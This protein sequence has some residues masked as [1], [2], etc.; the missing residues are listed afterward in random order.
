MTTKTM[1]LTITLNEPQQDTLERMRK[2]LRGSHHADL[3]VRKDG[4]DHHFEID[5]LRNAVFEDTP[6]SPRIGRMTTMTDLPA[7]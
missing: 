7:R 5:W 6:P 4:Q 3:T 2:A 1:R